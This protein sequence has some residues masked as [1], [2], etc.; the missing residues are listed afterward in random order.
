MK[1]ELS[2]LQAAQDMPKGAVRQKHHSS[3]SSD[4]RGTILS[5]VLLL[6][7][8]AIH[9]HPFPPFHLLLAEYV[10]FLAQ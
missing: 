8:P 1:A 9:F 2:T 3:L 4:G 10:T 7:S 5:E 6:N